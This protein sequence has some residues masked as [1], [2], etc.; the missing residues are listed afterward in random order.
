MV[1]DARFE[2]AAKPIRLM[3]QSVEDLTVLSALLQDA[4]GKASDFA[5]LAK[6]RRFVFVVNRYRWEID[7]QRR[8]P[9]ERVQAGV[10]IENALKV[11]SR[12]V[13]AGTDAPVNILDLAWA[14]GEDGAGS[15]HILCAG[16][17]EFAIEAEAL[18]VKLS[19][20]T[21]PWSAAQRPRH[22][23]A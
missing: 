1:E 9:G 3:A 11:R 14:A 6:S 5:Y 20:V 13:K 2:D 17:A 10:T 8:G 12:G 22:P 18:E 19:D 16:G 7:S 4:V 15:L 21:K 23:G